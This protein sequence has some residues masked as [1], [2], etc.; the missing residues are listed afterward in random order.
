MTRKQLTQLLEN[1]FQQL[2]IINMYR[3]DFE[4]I[5][6]KSALL[7]RIDKLLDEINEIRKKLENPT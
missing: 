3:E 6:G 7:L 1:R 4:K 2:K 5:E